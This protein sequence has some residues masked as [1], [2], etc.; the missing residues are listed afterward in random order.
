MDSS[1]Y[2]IQRVIG[3]DVPIGSKV[4]NKKTK[5]TYKITRIDPK[6]Y[7]LEHTVISGDTR[8]VDY[9]DPDYDVLVRA[10]E[11]V[12]EQNNMFSPLI[13]VFKPSKPQLSQ[14]EAYETTHNKAIQQI[15]Q[16]GCTRLKQINKAVVEQERSRPGEFAFYNSAGAGAYALHQIIK[17]IYEQLFRYKVINFEFFRALGDNPRDEVLKGP[18][19]F[20]STRKF[21]TKDSVWSDHS[22]RSSMI[23]TNIALHGNIKMGSES[24][25]NMLC[26][27][28]LF[29]VDSQKAVGIV[30]N[31]LAKVGIDG[32]QIEPIIEEVKKLMVSISKVQNYDRGAVLYQT[33]IPQKLVGELVYIAGV[34]GHPLDYKAFSG[35][36]L[37]I[38]NAVFQAGKELGN[39]SMI[40]FAEGCL[41]GIDEMSLKDKEHLFRGSDFTFMVMNAS[42][43]TAFWSALDEKTDPQ[44]RV[45][46]RPDVFQRPTGMAETLTYNNLQ[47]DINIAICNSV[48]NVGKNIQIQAQCI[49]DLIKKYGYLFEC[50]GSSNKTIDA[51]DPEL[52]FHYYHAMKEKVEEVN[53]KINTHVWD[54]IKKSPHMQE[55]INKGLNVM[56]RE[57]Q[58]PFSQEAMIQMLPD[59]LDKLIKFVKENIEAPKQEVLN[60]AKSKAVDTN[61]LDL[62]FE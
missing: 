25:F 56:C 15:L 29:D 38:L 9:N 49:R 13:N 6:G 1:A 39:K 36:A 5:N 8:Y 57:K 3:I 53:A 50:F 51:I 11:I 4:I 37:N 33:F 34:N 16:S 59:E 32:P 35:D 55:I 7:Q 62:L 41:K 26:N 31:M 10:P 24:S 45:L 12:H 27:G 61:L 23:S 22:E 43:T 18:E 47:D 48:Q 14:S 54:E 52:L 21:D 60:S 2:P 44:A 42:K 19:E 46:M 17:T 40:L 58:V 28:G 20:L 30:T